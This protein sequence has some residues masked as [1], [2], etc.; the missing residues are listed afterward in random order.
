LGAGARTDN[1]HSGRITF[2]PFFILANQN[3]KKPP[4][5]K[6]KPSPKTAKPSTQTKNTKNNK[7]SHKNTNFTQQPK[8]YQPP[9][10]QL[11]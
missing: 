11:Q 10:S 8:P 6:Q 2:S 9:L 1:N 3:R 4:S 5:N 7:K